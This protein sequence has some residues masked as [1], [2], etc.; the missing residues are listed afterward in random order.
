[1]PAE[2]GTETCFVLGNVCFSQVMDKI[3]S[4]KVSADNESGRWAVANKFLETAQSPN[5]RFP[6]LIS[7]VTNYSNYSNIRIVGTK[8]WYLIFVF[9]E[10]STSK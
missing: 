4:K 10:F 9:V 1:M 3:R 6:L 7:V 5:S 8:K 2:D